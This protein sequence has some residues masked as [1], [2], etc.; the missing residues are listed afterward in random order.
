[1]AEEIVGRIAEQQILKEMLHSKEAELVVV[2]GRRRIGKTFLI[3][4]YFEKQLAFEFTGA[5]EGTLSQQL[6]NFSKGTKSRGA[7][8]RMRTYRRRRNHAHFG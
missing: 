2:Y 8:S 1:M 3:R 5:Y 7:I 4:N 6:S